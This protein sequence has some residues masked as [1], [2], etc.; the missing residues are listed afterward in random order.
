M[1]ASGAS[2]ARQELDQ[3][4]LARAVAP[5]QS[6]AGTRRN[7]QP[8]AGQHCAPVIAGRGIVQNQQWIGAGQRFAHAK[9]EWRIHVRR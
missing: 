6:D 4:R 9:V 8:D 1:P 3:R 7:V 5:E 2:C